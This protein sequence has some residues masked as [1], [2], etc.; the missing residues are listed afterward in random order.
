MTVTMTPP[1]NAATAGPP[2]GTTSPQGQALVFMGVQASVEPFEQQRFE[3]L[4]DHTGQQ[5]TFVDAPGWGHGGMLTRMQRADLRHGVFDSVAGPMVSAAIERTPALATGPATVVG[6]SMGASLAAA[7]AASSDIQVDTMILIEPVGIR[8]WNPLS[9]L[10]AVRHEDQFTDTYLARNPTG[11]WEPWDR[12]G[13]AP[14]P[15]KWSDLATLG[16]AISRGRIGDDLERAATRG[17][18]RKL[19]IIRADSSRLCRRQ[20]VERLASRAEGL[21]IHTTC[22]TIAGHHPVWQS[23]PDVIEMAK[24]LEQG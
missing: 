24:L 21:G 13:E 9:L 14:P 4:A 23:V 5:I 1:I 2:D 7:A 19:H 12:R 22:H 3:A 20:D 11:S 8:R 15:H 16:W 18:P 10:G 17:A 6:Y